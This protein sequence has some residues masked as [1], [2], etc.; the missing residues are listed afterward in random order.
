MSKADGGSNFLH[1]IPTQELFTQ[2]YGLFS[3]LEVKQGEKSKLKVF[4][5]YSEE[6]LSH[7]RF[8]SDMSRL[9]K[10]NRNLLSRT[11]AYNYQQQQN[12]FKGQYNDLVGSGSN[13]YGDVGGNTGSC[14]SIDVCPDLILAAIAAAAAGAAFVIYQ[15]I[16]A[17]GKK[18]RKREKDDTWLT[19]LIMQFLYLGI[20]YIFR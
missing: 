19:R 1:T 8:F 12:K 4:L 17:R 15:A 14:F 10:V 16:T 6:I 11:T 2:V 5:Y 18:R 9:A 3:T 13:S 7:E 20:Y